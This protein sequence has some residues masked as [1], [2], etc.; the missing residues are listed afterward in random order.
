MYLYTVFSTDH[1]TLQDLE[2][3]AIKLWLE[4]FCIGPTA[5]HQVQTLQPRTQFVVLRKEL[6]RLDELRLVRVHGE[7]FP[8]LEFEELL[9]EI[10]LLGIQK[11]VISLEGFRR[12]YQASELVNAVVLFFENSLFKYPLL[13]EL[14]EDVYYTKD[15]IEE[16]DQVFDR[17]GQIKDDASAALAEISVGSEN[18]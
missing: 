15:I 8:Q 9:Q 3:E 11:A 18:V 12:I 13:K 6:Q 14:T 1:Q 2:F 10:K 7:R 17:N 16:I 4:K 5:I